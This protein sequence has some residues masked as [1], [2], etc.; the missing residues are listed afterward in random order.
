MLETIESQ[1]LK[2]LLDKIIHTLRN[3]KEAYRILSVT[4]EIPEHCPL[5]F[6]QAAENMGMQRMFWS[7]AAD[8][9]S[10][11]GIGTAFCLDAKDADTAS[12]QYAWENALMHADVYNPFTQAGTGLVAM[13][14]MAF[15]PL[16]EKT[17]LWENY[18]D[19][20]MTI[21]E[22]VLTKAKDR[23]Y[24]TCNVKV[25]QADHSQQ[26]SN[27][28]HAKEKEL[29]S[30][31]VSYTSDMSIISREDV[32]PDAW[33]RTV[34]YATDMIKAG[35]AQ[36]IVLAREV[37]LKLSAKVDIGGVLKHLMEG[38]PNSYVF[39]ISHGTDCFVGATP[40]RLVKLEAGK[41]LSTC[42]A[43][44]APRGENKAQDE[45]IG[46]ALLRDP[47]NLQEHDFV[48]Q[49]IKKAV[50]P[51]TK[52]MTVPEKPVLYKL[53]NLQHLYTPVEA[54][55]LRSQSIFPIVE[56]LHPTPALGGAPKNS[57]MQFIRKHELLDR[58]WYG[59]PIGWLD[60][61]NNGEFAVAIRSGLIQ[62]DEASL[63]AGCGVVADS[64]PEEEF[65]ETNVKLMPMLHVLGGESK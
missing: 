45:A 56:K 65:A 47:K 3:S 44:T 37:R 58:G 6:F 8:Q 63:F 25:K 20:E 17:E 2:P 40:E 13:G 11:V 54:D 46:S 52:N 14:G 51:Y 21:P 26:L 29:L 7:T 9:F 49:M 18:P 15:D 57:S 50:G 60:E 35:M 36:K 19:H 5:A 28:V 62:G 23:C 22:F 42:L 59:A 24:L 43:G 53:K 30:G 61:K 38:Q 4:K 31:K 41:L 33:K 12:L 64:D 48:V 34:S 16:K 39:A 10:M 27:Q 32:Q 55:L 1:Q